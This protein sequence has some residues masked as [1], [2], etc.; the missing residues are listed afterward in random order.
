M[1]EVAQLLEPCDFFNILTKEPRYIEVT[2][3]KFTEGLVPLT[4]DARYDKLGFK[5]NFLDMDNGAFTQGT[6]Y[7]W[8]VKYDETQRGY[9][10]GLGHSLYPLLSF[11]SGIE[12]TPILV[13][14]YDLYN[15]V[16]GFNLKATVKNKKLTRNH[17]TYKIIPINEGV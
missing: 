4:D 3:I 7:E 14:Q 5:I 11:I 12:D 9:Y 10:I 1:M 16:V 8:D 2:D 17:S 15:D 6:Y 13:S